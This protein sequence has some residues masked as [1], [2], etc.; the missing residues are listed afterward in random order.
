MN[1]LFN[2]S[3]C[4]YEHRRNGCVPADELQVIVKAAA[5]LLTDDAHRM[6]MVT[7]EGQEAPH[8][9]YEFRVLGA[10]RQWAIFYEEAPIERGA[11]SL[12]K[13]PNPGEKKQRLVN[14]H[15]IRRDNIRGR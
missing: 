14:Y 12:P 9:L 2:V 13:V 6:A 5:L 4:G 3:V 7:G 11:A 8:W 10:Q 15:V 1:L